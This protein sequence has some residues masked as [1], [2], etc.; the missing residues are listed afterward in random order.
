MAAAAAAATTTTT[1]ANG[2]PRSQ[3]GWAKWTVWPPLF[4]QAVALAAAAQQTPTRC[5][6][7]NWCTTST[8][9]RRRRSAAKHCSGRQVLRQVPIGRSQWAVLQQSLLV[10]VGVFWLLDRRCWR[11]HWSQR[12]QATTTVRQVQA[13]RETLLLLLLLLLLLQSTQVQ[14][15]YVC[16]CCVSLITWSPAPQMNALHCNQIV[17]ASTQRLCGAKS[18]GLP[19]SDIINFLAVQ[20]NNAH[21]CQES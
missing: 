17:D 10:V 8:V 5:T 7:V 18:F 16:S 4:S 1:T 9:P 19:F 11:R 13:G 2:S 12:K 6:R 15:R 21:S 20:Y 14:F 3:S